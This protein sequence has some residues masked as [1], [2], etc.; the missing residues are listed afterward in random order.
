MKRTLGV[1][2]GLAVVLVGE[3]R[4]SKSYV[5]AKKRACAEVGIASF[6]HEYTS[7]VKQEVI[8]DKV[9]NTWTSLIL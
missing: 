5:G 4:D 1:T 3:R 9:E 7:D 6:G 2:P 8:I